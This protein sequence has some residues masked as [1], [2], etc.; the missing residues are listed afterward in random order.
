MY[1]YLIY[2]QHSLLHEE[3]MTKLEVERQSQVSL[4]S[5]EQD[6]GYYGRVTRGTQVSKENVDI[7][8]LP[9]AIRRYNVHGEPSLTSL[10][11]GGISIEAWIVYIVYISN[12][13]D[14][15]SIV[16]HM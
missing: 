16:I 8:A 12:M 4:Y 2:E 5:Y 13:Y 1:S 6:T 15:Y 7:S 14:I 11:R 10:G 3:I 9:L